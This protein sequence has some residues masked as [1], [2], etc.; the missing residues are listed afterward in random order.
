MRKGGLRE[1]GNLKRRGPLQTG[2]ISLV[3]SSS[4]VAQRSG[5][6]GK[7]VSG[8]PVDAGL[9]R[10]LTREIPRICTPSAHAELNAL[11]E[12]LQKSVS[13]TIAPSRVS[14][15]VVISGTTYGAGQK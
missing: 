6:L 4:S 14:Q 9:N 15:V 5:A 8:P 10:G 13:S 1:N 3:D 11:M 2:A 12:R 7:G